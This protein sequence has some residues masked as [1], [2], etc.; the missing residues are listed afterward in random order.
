L[1][2]VVL[3]LQLLRLA[4]TAVHQSME[5]FLLAVAQAG[6]IAPAVVRAVVR[7]LQLAQIQQF[8]TQALLWLV[9][10]LL[11]MPLAGQVE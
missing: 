11:V 1:V 9:L 6:K 10:T 4:Q 8:L 5:W 3:E 2:L 7:Q